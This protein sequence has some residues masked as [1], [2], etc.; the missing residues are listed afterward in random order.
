M[1]CRA[2]CVIASGQA[3]L[4]EPDQDGGG[5]HLEVPGQRGRMADTATPGT[6]EGPRRH[7]AVGGEVVG[8]LLGLLGSA[9]VRGAGVEAAGV[10]VVDDVLE[11]V[12]QCQAAARCWLAAVEVCNV[13]VL[14]ILFWSKIN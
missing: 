10:A 9:A 13:Q 8:G 14:T 3:A 12:Q 7:Q 5:G 1:G 11:L 4:D 2:W 6:L